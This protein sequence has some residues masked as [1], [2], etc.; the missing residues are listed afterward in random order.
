MNKFNTADLCDEHELS[1]AEPIFKSFGANTHCHGRIKTVEAIED[2]SYVKKLLQT[3]GDGYVMVIDGKGSNRCAL[4]G[5]NLAAL[6]VENN[7][8]GII[9]NGSI[10]DSIEINKIPISIKALNLVPNK[11][12]K[13]D[14]GKYRLDLSF[15]GIT[16]RENEYIYSDPDGIVIAKKNLL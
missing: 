12:E 2:N 8:S 15:A 10:R 3:N 11:S 6:A 4:V 16:F 9:V 1:I 5:D 13:K 7:W 14:I